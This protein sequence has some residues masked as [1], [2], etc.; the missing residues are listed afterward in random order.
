MSHIEN[1]ALKLFAAQV[2][3]E[4]L[5]AQALIQRRGSG[6]ELRHFLDRAAS[7]DSLK[8]VGLDEVR[9]LAQNTAAGEFRPLKSAPTLSSGWRI[10]AHNSDELGRALDQLYPGAVADWFANRAENPPVTNYREYVNRQSGMY[11]ITAM[12]SDAQVSQVIQAVCNRENCLKCRQWTVPGATPDFP[13]EKSII[14]CLEP[15]AIL[16]ESARKAMRA[17]QQENEALAKRGES[18]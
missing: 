15:C 3:T 9:A 5:M 12:L 13:A 14:P 2:E 1:P 10:I 18:G 6:Y 11:R 7:A 17:I 16:M 4:L 8:L